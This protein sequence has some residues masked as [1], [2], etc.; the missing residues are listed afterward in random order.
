VLGALHE[1]MSPGIH[2]LRAVYPLVELLTMPGLFSCGVYFGCMGLCQQ[3]DWVVLV[4]GDNLGLVL[5][6]R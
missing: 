4:H 5:V 3:A 6:R 2:H 1:I